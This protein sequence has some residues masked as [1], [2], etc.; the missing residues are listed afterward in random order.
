VLTSSPKT[1]QSGEKK[2]GKIGGIKG[3]M[4]DEEDTVYGRTDRLCPAAGGDGNT[5]PVERVEAD[6]ASECWSMA[7]LSNAEPSMLPET[8]SSFGSK[9]RSTITVSIGR[10]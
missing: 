3:K 6:I 8:Y 10:C 1:G 7:F 5:G 4:S 2:S 9:N